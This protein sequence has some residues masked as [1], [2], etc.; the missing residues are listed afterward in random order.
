M[1]LT[2][3][4]ISQMYRMNE[5]V[6]QKTIDLYNEG[7]RDED[8][9]VLIK[10]IGQN[11]A[12]EGLCLDGNKLTLADGKLANAI[13]K[14]TT[15]KKLR[16]SY[17]N[18]NDEGI[19]HLANALKENNTLEVLDLGSNNIGDEGAKCLADML[20][21]NKSLQSIGLGDNNIG[22]EGAKCIADMLA[23]NKTLQWISLANNNISDKGAESI[24]ASLVVNTM[25]EMYG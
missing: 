11:I 18:I 12:P 16:L 20:V 15:I 25:Y 6:K 3:N 13:A 24:A 17:N 8:I 9:D 7:L 22:D 4:A 14:N 2:T 10:A 19:K 5:L 1:S 21:A 23:V